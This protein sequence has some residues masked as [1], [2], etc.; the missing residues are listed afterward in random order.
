MAIFS[1]ILGGV[2]GGTSIA[3]VI[4][5]VDSYSS[6]LNK[7][8]T[9]FKL[10]GKGINVSSAAMIGLAG[11]ATVAIAGITA[12][13][14]RG[15][16]VIRIQE[17][18]NRIFGESADILL[19]D[20]TE[21]ANGM[22]S[23]YEAMASANR[24]FL[25]GIKKE[26]FTELMAVEAARGKLMG[27]TVSKSFDDI[28]TGIGRTS[29]LILD[30]LGIIIDLEQTYEDY[31][32]GLDTTVDALS[33]LDKKQAL[34]NKI[35]EQSRLIIM[36]DALAAQTA[37]DEYERLSTKVNNFFDTL[38]AGTAKAMFDYNKTLNE[39]LLLLDTTGKGIE[40]LNQSASEVE[41]M[42]QLLRE[43]IDLNTAMDDT[44]KKMQ[45]IK[46][47]FLDFKVTR[48]S[49]DAKADLDIAKLQQELGIAEGKLR[50][51]LGPGPALSTAEQA[52]FA[53]KET[54]EVDRIK[55]L[56]DEAQARKSIVDDTNKIASL[57]REVVALGGM[58]L[59]TLRQRSSIAG[60][61]DEFLGSIKTKEGELHTILKTQT[62]EY[63]EQNR[64]LIEELEPAEATL[65]T[66]S[67]S[68]LAAH[69]KTTLELNKQLRIMKNIVALSGGSYG[70]YGQGGGILNFIS[71]RLGNRANAVP[72]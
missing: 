68:R 42:Q 53:P 1:D 61:F 71:E 36:Q 39:T 15:L 45:G 26:D 10:F 19:K 30:N 25:L 66:D 48:T 35:L 16:K 70:L 55:G 3:V 8:N 50:S 58:N 2:A 34:T 33:E 64:I 72:T 60:G 43:T 14:L 69:E 17:G 40:L 54:A 27:Q 46:D 9:K 22:I 59:D 31:A 62:A 24:A 49:A 41:G 20:M 18:F 23:N 63:N 44:R 67:E 13:T 11:A 5:A 4:K 56:L 37:A 12:L 65:L 47:T 29:R 51:K 21:A 57:E 32:D 52:T 28:V 7:A 6:E 38:G